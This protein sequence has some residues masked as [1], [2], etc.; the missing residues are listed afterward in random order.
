MQLSF[1][2]YFTIDIVMFTAYLSIFA[3]SPLPDKNREAVFLP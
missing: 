3:L 1:L 2:I